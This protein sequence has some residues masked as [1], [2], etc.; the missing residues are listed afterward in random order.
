MDTKHQ[1]VLRLSCKQL[2]ASVRAQIS[3]ASTAHHISRRAALTLQRS[4]P[5]L[6]SLSLLN[7]VSTHH[8]Q[9]LSRLT[10]LTFAPSGR[11]AGS[12]I[13]VD[14][15][16]LE[17]LPRLHT[18]HLEQVQMQQLSPTPSCVMAA[19]TQLQAL[20]LVDCTCS[21]AHLQKA[22]DLAALPGVTK[23]QVVDKSPAGL[24]RLNGL[25]NLHQVWRLTPSI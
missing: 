11:S 15:A 3:H 14:L 10:R 22:Q 2:A 21:G 24:A 9:L 23:L 8:L 1:A 19:I 16:P 12:Q 18:L 4:F 5:Q 17:D 13:T 6:C 7:P 25:Q 20:R